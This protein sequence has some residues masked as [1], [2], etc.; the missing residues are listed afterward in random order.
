MCRWNILES[1]LTYFLYSE[2]LTSEF[3]TQLVDLLASQTTPPSSASSSSSPLRLKDFAFE[4][5][6]VGEQSL[7]MVCA[8]HHNLPPHA[9]KHTT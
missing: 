6:S 4:F 2:S 7:F 1:P 9:L 5:T 3:L 8:Q